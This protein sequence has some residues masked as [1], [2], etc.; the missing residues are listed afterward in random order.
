MSQEPSNR[1]QP[2]RRRPSNQEQHRRDS[3]LGSASSEL[4]SDYAYNQSSA[5]PI[6]PLLQEREEFKA[7]LLATQKLGKT[8]VNPG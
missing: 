5:Q 8:P 4:P 3:S 2:D 6:D 7:V 1:G